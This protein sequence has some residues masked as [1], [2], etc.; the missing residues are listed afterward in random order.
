MSFHCYVDVQHSILEKLDIIISN[1]KAQ[2]VLLNKLANTMKPSKMMGACTLVEDLIPS[3][4]DSITNLDALNN[5]LE[6][7]D[8]QK[9]LVNLVP[10]FCQTV[11]FPLKI[12]V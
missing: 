12:T 8:F 11:L 10:L 3:P 1:E 7:Q 2:N 5:R 9:Q 4:V 6:A